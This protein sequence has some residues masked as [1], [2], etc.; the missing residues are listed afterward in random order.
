MEVLVSIFP[1]A[2][3]PLSTLNSMSPLGFI[4]I[5]SFVRGVDLL[6]RQVE[7]AHG[8]E[9]RHQKDDIKPSVVFH[10]AGIWALFRDQCVLTLDVILSRSAKAILFFLLTITSMVCSSRRS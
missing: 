1:A 7:D 9:G 10:F 6:V 4:E 8:G 2:S 3:L 5:L